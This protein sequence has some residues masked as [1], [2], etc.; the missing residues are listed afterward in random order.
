MSDL[1]GMT[2]P[3]LHDLILRQSGSMLVMQADLAEARKG[4]AGW[5]HARTEQAIADMAII[6]TLRRELDEAVA[7]LAAS[8]RYASVPE[9]GYI[10][11]RCESC[12]GLA[13]VPSQLSLVG[14]CGCRACVAEKQRDALRVE[15]EIARQFVEAAAKKP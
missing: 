13:E 15:L 1:S 8:P 3:E 2:V 6:G 5:K 12:G 7:L 14:L 4:A 9:T 11:R 10:I